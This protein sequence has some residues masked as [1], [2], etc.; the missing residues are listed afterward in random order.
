MLYLKVI[1]TVQVGHTGFSI[2]AAKKANMLSL[3]IGPGAGYNLV[4]VMSVMV[5]SASCSLLDVPFLK[6]TTFDQLSIFWTT[7]KWYAKHTLPCGACA[8]RTIVMLCKAIIA[9]PN[10][11]PSWLNDLLIYVLVFSTP[12]EVQPIIWRGAT[13]FNRRR[14]QVKA[15]HIPRATSRGARVL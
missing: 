14:W 1:V 7:I 10:M 9:V 15:E 13:N 8:K 5:V 3:V 4:S 6:K 11:E 12:A 2:V